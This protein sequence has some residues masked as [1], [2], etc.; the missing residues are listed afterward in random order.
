MFIVIDVNNVRVRV[1]KDAKQIGHTKW[2]DSETPIW[3][4]NMRFKTKVFDKTSK[5]KMEVVANT[6]G[7]L[8]VISTFNFDCSAWFNSKPKKFDA[9][10]TTKGEKLSFEY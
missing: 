8:N 3:E 10:S 1:L 9:D 6:D 7:N 2:K 5:I 4:Q